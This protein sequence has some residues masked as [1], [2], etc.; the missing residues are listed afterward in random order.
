[1]NRLT[2]CCVR[3]VL[4]ALFVGWT[5]PAMAGDMKGKIKKVDANRMEF[6]LDE[7]K[8]KTLT[9]QMDE[10]AQ[11][12]IDGKESQLSDLRA[13]DEVTVRSRQV[14][15]QWMAIEVRCKRK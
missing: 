15:E 8:G 2:R 3:I 6:V 13:G 7:T 4:L 11:V 1:M 5:A 12:V 9:F 10:D 14:G